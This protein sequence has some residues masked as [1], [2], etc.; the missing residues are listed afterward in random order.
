MCGKIKILHCVSKRPVLEHLILVR[1][2]GFNDLTTTTKPFDPCVEIGRN[3]YIKE[4]CSPGSKSLNPVGL[5]L[6]RSALLFLSHKKEIM[7]LN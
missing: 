2:A 6:G 5:Q 3:E 1:G 7:F 4:I